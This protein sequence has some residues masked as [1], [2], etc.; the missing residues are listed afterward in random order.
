MCVSP[1]HLVG[2]LFGIPLLKKAQEFLLIDAFLELGGRILVCSPC[3]KERNIDP[4]DLI[5]KSEVIACAT[6][7]AECCKA[8]AVLNYQ[9]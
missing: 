6:V 5:E 7:I 3:I 8:N 9:W 1:F 4:S 2:M